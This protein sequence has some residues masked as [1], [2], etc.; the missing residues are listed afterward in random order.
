MCIRDSGRFDADFQGD[1]GVNALALDVVREANHR[2]LSDR[3]MQ[4]QRRLNFRRA[5]PVA[6]DVDHVIH[7]PG[8]PP[9]AL[10]LIHI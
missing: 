2:R 9:V 7:P 1:I 3:R 4:H 10:S 8:D 5:H 6:G